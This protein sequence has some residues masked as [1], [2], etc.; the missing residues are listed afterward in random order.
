VV[1]ILASCEPKL[2]LHDACVTDAERAGHGATR[3][4]ARGFGQGLATRSFCRVVTRCGLGAAGKAH[5]GPHIPR[6]PRQI[7]RR[8]GPPWPRGPAQG[9]PHEHLTRTAPGPLRRARVVSRDVARACSTPSRQ[10]DR[11]PRTVTPADAEIS[12]QVLA[13]RSICGAAGGLHR[14][15]RPRRRERGEFHAHPGISNP[16]DGSG[17]ATPA[18][19][20]RLRI[21]S[22]EFDGNRRGRVR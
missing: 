2:R 21:T 12:R 20:A 13:T 14:H 10:G 18:P 22:R 15:R 4:S 17:V 7:G 19:I 16:A 5:P 1:V 6:S 8:G 9:S 3:D 11:P